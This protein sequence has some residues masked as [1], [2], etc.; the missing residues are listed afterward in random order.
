MTYAT[1]IRAGVLAIGLGML[2]GVA[3]A[4]VVSLPANL[5]GDPVG[6]GWSWQG[7]S[8]DAGT[9][10]RSTSDATG[11]GDFSYGV[12]NNVFSLTASDAGIIGGGWQAGD[13]IIGLGGVMMGQ[14]IYSPSLVA[15]FGSSAASFSASSTTTAPGDGNGSFSSG[16]A[17]V[18]GV[19]VDFNYEFDSGPGT[20]TG[21]TARP[22][23]AGILLTP[24]HV[25]YDGTHQFGGLM[26]TFCDVAFFSNAC[27]I[28]SDF[29][30]VVADFTTDGGSQDILNSFE[31]ALDLSYLQ[32]AGYDPLPAADGKS[33]MAVQR[34]AGAYIDALVSPD[35]TVVNGLQLCTPPSPQNVAGAYQYDFD[36]S[37]SGG[38]TVYIPLLDPNANAVMLSDGAATVQKIPGPAP[39]GWLTDTMLDA[40]GKDTAF[41]DPAAWLEITENGDT[42]FRLRV[43]SVN[44]PTQGPIMVD[45]Q[46]IDPP[47]PGSG[48]SVPEPGALPLLAIALGSLVFVRLKPMRLRH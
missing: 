32:R 7:N 29:A 13:Q 23:L 38:G 31:I 15:K 20:G 6:D 19:Q 48:L 46:I 2:P 34:F 10:I 33:D 40:M 12:Y 41:A 3:Q 36:V 39:T 4:I 28:G 5:T 16:M 8:L 26:D 44:A 21:T 24:D 25:L 11:P 1:C 14:Y 9:Y 17:G 47:V 42:S 22:G 27:N 35:C 43:D 30:R 45:G 37:T 18:G